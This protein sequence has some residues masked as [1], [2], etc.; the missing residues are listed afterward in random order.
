MNV[1][2]AVHEAGEKSLGE[3]P[4]GVSVMCFVNLGLP[5]DLAVTLSDSGKS[6]EE[7]ISS[8][9]AN[10]ASY[11][12]TMPLNDLQPACPVPPSNSIDRRSDDRSDATE[13]NALSVL[14]VAAFALVVVAFII[15]LAYGTMA[16]T[17]PAAVDEGLIKGLLKKVLEML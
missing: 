6:V 10:K 2:Q 12:F 15:T 8:L 17:D 13:H 5:D 14:V 7:R 9:P 16:V 4:W 11:I 3:Y 1:F